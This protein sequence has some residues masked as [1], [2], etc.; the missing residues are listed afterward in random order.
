[1]ADPETP[2]D[3]AFKSLDKR[4]DALATATR[5]EPK[6][7]GEVGTSAGYRV[8]GELLG[9]IFIGLGLGTLL[10]RFAG[11]TPWGLI[12]GVV[13]GLAASIFVV[14]RSVSRT[15]ATPPP[16][17]PGQVGGDVDRGDLLE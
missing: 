1:M 14:A 16:T 4:L 15:G 7:F 11:T 10:D 13:I 8:L 12:C 5:R 9:G 17:G 3:K 2:Q 6:A